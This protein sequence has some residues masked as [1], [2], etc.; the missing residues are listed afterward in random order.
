MKRNVF[1]MFLYVIPTSWGQFTNQS[2]P[3]KRETKYSPVQRLSDLL[4]ATCLLNKFC[5]GLSLQLHPL[6]KLRHSTLQS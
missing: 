6:P 4:K 2:S 5:S 3:L 1:H